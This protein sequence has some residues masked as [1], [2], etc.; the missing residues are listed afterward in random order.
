MG[1]GRLMMMIMTATAIIRKTE[2]DDLWQLRKSRK[3]EKLVL[4]GNEVPTSGKKGWLVKWI[5]CLI[6]YLS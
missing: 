2:I 1:I 5:F 3:V 4:V 6:N